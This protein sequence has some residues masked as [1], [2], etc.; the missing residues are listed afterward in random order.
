[1]GANSPVY[2]EVDVTQCYQTAVRKPE[3]FRVMHPGGQDASSREHKTLF[4][5]QFTKIAN[6][7]GYWSNFEYGSFAHRRP[8]MYN[9][10]GL[11]TFMHNNCNAN[12]RRERL[13]QNL[14]S[15]VP[16]DSPGRCLHNIDMPNQQNNKDPTTVVAGYK[17]YLSL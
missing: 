1:M 16:I 5:Q 3:R 9:K 6:P 15:I 17:F 14:M 7:G 2:S 8:E 12:S 13:V 11:I 4:H 10:Q